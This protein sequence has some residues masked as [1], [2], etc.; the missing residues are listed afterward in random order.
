MVRTYGL[1]NSKGGKGVEGRFHPIQTFT[2]SEN[3]NES[4]TKWKLQKG[5]VK[6]RAL[7]IN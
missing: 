5:V 6:R 2:K 1:T 7:P 4:V 3:E